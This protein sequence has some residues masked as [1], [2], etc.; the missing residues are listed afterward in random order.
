[1][2]FLDNLLPILTFVGIAI[3]VIFAIL[4]IIGKF[5][6]KVEQGQALIINKMKNEPDVTTTGGIVYPVIHKMEVMD[7]STK[8]MVLERKDKGGLICKDNIRADIA[9]TFYIRV[10]ENKDDILR[11]AKHVGCARA[12]EHE[13]LQ[14]LFEAKFS[15]A[16][17]TV[18]KRMDFVE[19]FTHRNE[20]RDNIKEVIGQDLSGYTLEDVAIDYLEQTSIEKLDSQNILDAEGIRRI[21]EMT[22]AQNVLTNQLKCDER[23]K[24]EIQNQ[25]ATEKSLEIERQKQDAMSRQVREIETVKAREH[26]EAEKVRHEERLKSEQARIQSEESIGISEQ[27]KQRELD[28]AEQNRL[29]VLGIEEEKVLRSREI[30]VIERER[31]TEILRINKEKALEVERKEIADVVR[32]RV[33]VEKS[34][35]EEQETYQ[36]CAGFSGCRT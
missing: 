20:F 17:K 15:E 25:E 32:D 14:E 3:A 11:V 22:A 9:I 8:R 13:T 31:E 18:G 27:N 7:I 36:R 21:T 35:A 2:E 34:V 33:I 28:I 30:E 23:A 24:V 10:N 26:A 29:R 5:Y 1:M 16:L 19:L 6:R 12:S 4:L